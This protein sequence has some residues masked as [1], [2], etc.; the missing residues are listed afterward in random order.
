MM[1]EQTC[2]GVRAFASMLT[3][4]LALAL[5]LVLCD[6]LHLQVHAD[7]GWMMDVMMDDG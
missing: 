7:D 3:L 1:R 6:M 5:V 4:A 2:L